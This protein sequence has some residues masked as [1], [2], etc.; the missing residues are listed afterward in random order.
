MSGAVQVFT[1]SLYKIVVDREKM[2]YLVKEGT[3]K[4]KILEYWKPT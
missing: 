2:S 3:T 4:Q 1:G